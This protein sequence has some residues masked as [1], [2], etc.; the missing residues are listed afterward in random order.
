MREF[1]VPWNCIK[2]TANNPKTAHIL[3]FV[4]VRY[5]CESI[6]SYTDR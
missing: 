2:V 6:C 3:R 4:Y 5:P 1:K